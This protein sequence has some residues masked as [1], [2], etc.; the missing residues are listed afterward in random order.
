MKTQRLSIVLRCFCT[1]A[2]RLSDFL[3]FSAASGI[4]ASSIGS[5]IH[6]LGNRDAR[7]PR[8][9]LLSCDGFR[10]GACEGSRTQAEAPELDP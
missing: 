3:K 4:L 2:F 9:L 1:R 10:D 6:V 5:A 8:D 7:K